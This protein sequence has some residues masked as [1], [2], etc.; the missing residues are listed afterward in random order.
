MLFAF[1]NASK[2]MQM[3]NLLTIIKGTGSNLNNFDGRQ[4]EYIKDDD[5]RD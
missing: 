4:K 1:K 5:I 2:F 3:A